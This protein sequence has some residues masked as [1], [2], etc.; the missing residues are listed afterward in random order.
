MPLARSG[1]SAEYRSTLVERARGTSF[2][3]R[4]SPTAEPPRS[5]AARVRRNVR[6]PPADRARERRL[7]RIRAGLA[8]RSCSNVRAPRKEHA[9]AARRTAHVR[10]ARRGAAL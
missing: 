9:L 7:A 1:G 4:D 5:R 6:E 8:E 2:L 3:V 10:Q